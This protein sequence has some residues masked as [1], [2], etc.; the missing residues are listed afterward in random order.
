MAG[1][2]WYGWQAS[3]VDAGAATLW[4]T[5]ITMLMIDDSYDDGGG[6]RLVQG[7]SVA[8]GVG[9]LAGAPTF[10]LVHR[11]PWH[12]LGSFGMRAVLPILGGAIGLNTQSCPPPNAD[13]GNCGASGLLAG[14]A[15]GAVLAMAL[16]DS[17]LAWEPRKGTERGARQLGVSPVLS[18]D[19]RR[20]LRVFG[21]F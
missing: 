10:H 1:R 8:G 19:G 16:D 15:V 11:R 2:R 13:Y 9:Y 14:A 6:E 18:K 12:A 20:E 3:S 21:T 5:S 7:L 17:L 4:V